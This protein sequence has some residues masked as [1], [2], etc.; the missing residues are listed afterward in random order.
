MLRGCSFDSGLSQYYVA[1][2]SGLNLLKAKK[3]IKYDTAGTKTRTKSVMSIKI[4]I[5]NKQ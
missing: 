3:Y 2:L 5:K 1:F 4:F